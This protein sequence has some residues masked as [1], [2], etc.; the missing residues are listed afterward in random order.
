MTL[1]WETLTRKCCQNILFT[2]PTAIFTFKLLNTKLYLNTYIH[3]VHT[4]VHLK[5]HTLSL[6]EKEKNYA[7]SHTHKHTHSHA[8]IFEKHTQTH[9]HRNTWFDT[10]TYILIHTLKQTQ[11]HTH[12][13]KQTYAH[14]R[15]YFQ[16]KFQ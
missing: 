13:H 12:I 6:C 16:K 7:H 3:I 10:N 15:T 2:P 5:I 1:Y 8:I 14:N 9:N 11:T 4:L